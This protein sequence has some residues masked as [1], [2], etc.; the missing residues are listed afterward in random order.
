MH[1]SLVCTATTCVQVGEGGGP[2]DHNFATT[3]SDI[4]CIGRGDWWWWLHGT[5]VFAWV[6]SCGA[7][8]TDTGEISD[9]ACRFWVR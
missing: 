7:W 6:S 2:C 5:V 3:T 1:T 8:A 4:R 9:R